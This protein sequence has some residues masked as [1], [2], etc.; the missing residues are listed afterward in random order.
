MGN[1]IKPEYRD[2]R[3]RIIINDI[4]NHFDNTVK[5]LKEDITGIK[6]DMTGMKKDMTGMKKDI[7]GIKEDITEIKEDMTGIKGKITTIEV[8]H[9]SHME[10]YMSQI[11]KK[12]DVTYVE[13]DKREPK[14][15]K[16][17]K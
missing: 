8:N 14:Q 16:T 6:E 4:K 10:V 15:L 9:L 13:P 1:G 5:P 17:K 11:C 3:E 2:E 7:T 12:N